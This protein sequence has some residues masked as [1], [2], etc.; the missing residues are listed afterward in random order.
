VVNAHQRRVARRK[1]T[2]QILI[3]TIVMLEAE[4]IHRCLIRLFESMPMLNVYVPSIKAM[5]PVN[6]V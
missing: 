3:D 5:Q 2:R 1:A 4:R 6:W